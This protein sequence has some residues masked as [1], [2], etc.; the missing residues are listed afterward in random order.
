[1]KNQG[2]ATFFTG[3]IYSAGWSPKRNALT[4]LQS[5]TVKSGYLDAQV[6]G[7]EVEHKSEIIDGGKIHEYKS[8][9]S[10][11]YVDAGCE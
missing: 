1:M 5:C 2:G 6:V 11:V 4:L 10:F 9:K 7:Q 3:P 8:L